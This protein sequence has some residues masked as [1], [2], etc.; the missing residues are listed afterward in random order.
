VKGETMDTI[1]LENYVRPSQ[2][3]R[4][5]IDVAPHDTLDS[6]APPLLPLPNYTLST[7][8][9]ACAADMTKRACK[10]VCGRC[11]FVWDCSEL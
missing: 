10:V 9:P 6:A 8:C 2:A 7:V 1:N 3:A 11:G 5:V 4:R